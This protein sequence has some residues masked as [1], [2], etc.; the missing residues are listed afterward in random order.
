M[1]IKTLT[2]L[3]SAT[4]LMLIASGCNKDKVD[5]SAEVKP[6]LNKRCI[7]CHGG[8]KKN[9]GF[10]VLFRHEAI[11]TTDSGKPSI[12]P[13]HP[14]LSEV[15][16]RINSS[17]PEVRMPYKEDPL[18]KEE[19]EILTRWIDEGAEWGDHWAYQPPK[20]VEVPKDKTLLSSVGSTDGEEWAK[21]DIDYFILEKLEKEA[22]QPS[23]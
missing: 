19:I 18:T 13:G 9:G 4:V 11:D 16:R 6:I 12:V 17:D 22:L 2:W 23:P 10:S 14:E 1:K 21:N 3:T 7:S 8:V 20:P 5:F 15:V